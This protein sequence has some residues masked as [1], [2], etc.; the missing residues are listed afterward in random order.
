MVSFRNIY[1][2]VTHYAYLILVVG[3]LIIY[4]LNFNDSK[5]DSLFCSGYYDDPYNKYI[6]LMYWMENNL[7]CHFTLDDDYNIIQECQNE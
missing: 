2:N 6:D 5:E 3:S 1:T 7:C 4:G